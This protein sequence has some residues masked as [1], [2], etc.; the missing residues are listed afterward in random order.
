MI[1][2]DRMAATSSGSITTR[3]LGAF[4]HVDHVIIVGIGGGI[5]HYTDPEMVLFLFIL[6]KFL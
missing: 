5:P 1:G 2:G 4:Q 3:L 6:N